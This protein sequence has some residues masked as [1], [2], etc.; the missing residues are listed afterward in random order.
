[1][2]GAIG[3]NFRHLFDIQGRDARQ[4]FWYW[5]LF[6]VVLNVLVALGISVPMTVGAV[7]AS[8]ENA[9]GDRA[10]ADA[11]VLVSMVGMARTLVWVSI[12]VGIANIVLMAS[13]FVRRLHDSGKSAIWAILAGAVQ[14]V[15]LFTALTQV[16]DAEAMIRAAVAAQ[17]SDEVFAMQGRMAWQSVIGW[18]PLIV[19]IVF[20][21]M[22]SDEGAN[23]YGEEPVRF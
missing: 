7:S 16:A 10:A 5:V 15:A 1:M 6:V 13:A 17:S 18:L 4:T 11:A 22:K 12:V 8:L 2:L 19:L 3:Y 21:V 20:G 23:R 14:L 9:G